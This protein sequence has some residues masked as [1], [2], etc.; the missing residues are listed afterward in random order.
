MLQ[1]S[2]LFGTNFPLVKTAPKV[3]D[4]G[5]DYSEF[6]VLYSRGGLLFLP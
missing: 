4:L 2:T 3:R 5:K 6:C 1:I